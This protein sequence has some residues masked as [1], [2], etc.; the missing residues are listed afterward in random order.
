MISPLPESD[1]PEYD[2][3]KRFAKAVLAVPKSEVTP[4]EDLGETR[5]PKTPD[6]RQD[7]WRGPGTGE[8]QGGTSEVSGERVAAV[9]ETGGMI[10]PCRSILTNSVSG[11][12]LKPKIAFVTIRPFQ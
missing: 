10:Q 4:P 2:R 9:S 6:R 5:S 11:A 1:E 12:K 7:R 3:F 8:T